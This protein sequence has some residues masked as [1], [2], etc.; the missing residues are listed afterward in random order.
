MECH[1][2]L[3]GPFRIVNG[4]DVLRAYESIIDVIDDRTDKKGYDTI[5]FY[6]AAKDRLYRK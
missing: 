3:F 2:T 4:G 5:D 1:H 6:E